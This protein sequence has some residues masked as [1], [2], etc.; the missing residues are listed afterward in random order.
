[1]LA[2]GRRYTFGPFQLNPHEGTLVASGELVPLAPKPFDV[3]RVLVEN[4]GHVVLTSELM[5]LVWPDR[6]VEEANL[7]VSVS[8]LRKAL[9]RRQPDTRYVQTVPKRGYR[10]VEHVREIDADEGE[11]APSRS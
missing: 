10:F 6:A 8:V 9:A 1:M 5:A 7:T 2:G 11:W 4:H 3:L